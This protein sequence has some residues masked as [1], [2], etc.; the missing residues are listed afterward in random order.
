MAAKVSFAFDNGVLTLRG[1]QKVVEISDKQAVF[2]M[3]NDNLTVRGGGL[4]VIKLDKEQ[5]VVVLEV[6]TLAAITIRQGGLS[7]K[8]LF[9]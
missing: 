5:C 4:N 6:K 2:K 8:G 7:F 9:R 1:V 3:D